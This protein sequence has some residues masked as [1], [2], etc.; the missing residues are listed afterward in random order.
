MVLITV[1]V[2]DP[3]DA[4]LADLPFGLRIRARAWQ[5]DGERADGKLL[6]ATVHVTRGNERNAL[7]LAHEAAHAL[8]DESNDEMH[9]PW[10][11]F[12]GLV[13]HALRRPIH[14]TTLELQVGEILAER[15]RWDTA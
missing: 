6:A 10:W 14:L 4:P 12:C 2:H 11:H 3:H 13:G 1:Q 9:H 5:T 15:G 8:R 7:L